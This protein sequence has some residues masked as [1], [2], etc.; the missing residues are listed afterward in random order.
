MIARIQ[1]LAHAAALLAA[2]LLVLGTGCNSGPAGNA[3]AAVSQQAMNAAEYRAAATGMLGSGAGVL[4]SGDL[5]GNGHIQLLVANPLSKASGDPAAGVSVS[6]AA[7]L[8]K[9]GETWREILLADDSLKNSAGFLGDSPRSTVSSWGLRYAQTDGRLTLYFAP[10]EGSAG[11][12]QP[13]IEVRWNPALHRYQ[14][15]D[16]SARRFLTESSI[17]APPSYRINR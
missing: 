2:G 14:S 5:A 10:V 12:A 13:G 7:V 17:F 3:S 1:R 9:D 6:S 16:H 15:F 11:A 8:E 4:L